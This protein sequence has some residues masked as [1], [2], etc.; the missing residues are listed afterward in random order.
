M[1]NALDDIWR[2]IRFMC[3]HNINKHLFLFDDVEVKHVRFRKNKNEV[4][5]YEDLF[6]V[7]I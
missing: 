3:T 4:L 6:C 7:G 5:T 1:K 2:K